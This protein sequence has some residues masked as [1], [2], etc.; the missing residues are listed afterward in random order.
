MYPSNF[1]NE[2]AKI[3][4]RCKSDELSKIISFFESAHGRAKNM[5]CTSKN[6]ERVDGYYYLLSSSI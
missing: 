1:P 6:T 4:R 5:E 3:E 2:E